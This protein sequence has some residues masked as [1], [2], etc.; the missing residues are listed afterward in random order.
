MAEYHRLHVDLRKRKYRL[1]A[2]PLEFFERI[3]QAFAPADALRIALALVDGRPVAGAVYVVWGD[4][5]Y[6][7]FGASRAEFLPL[8]PNDALHWRLIRWAHD[9]GLRT[10]DWGLSDLDQPGLVAYKRNWASREG[11]IRDPERRRAGPAGESA[12][13][14]RLL[15]AC[16]RPAHRPVRARRRVRP[17]RRGPLPL[18]LLMIRRPPASCS[19]PSCEERSTSNGCTPGG[20][21][22]LGELAAGRALPEHRGAGQARPGE[23]VP[24]HDDVREEAGQH[25]LGALHLALVPGE[26]DAAGAPDVARLPRLVGGGDQALARRRCG[27]RCRR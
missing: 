14:G 19:K 27:R 10:L 26:L 18:L 13:V 1:L 20:H 3:R 11:R 7:K 22:V 24:P 6:Y 15:T 21:R 25:R 2:Q 16:H 12:E 23:G 9:R 17:G 5:V 8:R 4:T